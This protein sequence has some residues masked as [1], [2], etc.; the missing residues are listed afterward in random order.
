MVWV[1]ERTIY[2]YKAWNIPVSVWIWLNSKHPDT[3][4][5]T[6]QPPLLNGVL[7]YNPAEGQS[8][9][10]ESNKFWSS[11]WTGWWMNVCIKSV[12]LSVS[13]INLFI[14]P[15]PS[16][17]PWCNSKSECLMWTESKKTDRVY[18]SHLHLQP[19]YKLS[20]VTESYS[21]FPHTCIA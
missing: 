6:S 12:S 17:M 15:S 16:F 2:T 3:G 10:V 9:H 14:N 18:K 20:S 4:H 5:L 8:V 7:A 13:L 1:R 21:V 11:W 19:C